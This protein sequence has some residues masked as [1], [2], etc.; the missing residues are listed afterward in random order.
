MAIGVSTA[1]ANARLDA[2]ESTIGVSPLLRLYSGTKPTDC[3]AALSGNT[4]LAEFNLPS[5]W[6]A[7]AVYGMKAGSGLNWWEVPVIATGTVS[8]FR[9][10]DTTGT[11]CHMQGTVSGIGG[12]GSLQMNNTTL[13][14]VDS[15]AITS[16]YLRASEAPVFSGALTSTLASLGWTATGTVA[17]ASWTSTRFNQTAYSNQ[18]V[19]RNATVPTG[20]GLLVSLWAKMPTPVTSHPTTL[21]NTEIL[22]VNFANWY[23]RCIG[24]NFNTTSGSTGDFNANSMFFLDGTAV[25][26]NP[27]SYVG[28]TT[29]LLDTG[30]PW[31]YE[32]GWVFFAF[33]F[34][35]DGSGNL[36]LNM[37]IRYAGQAVQGPYT[38]NYTLANIRAD[39]QTNSGWTLAHANAFT[40]SQTI[41]EIRINGD[42][43]SDAYLIHA[44]VEQATTTATNAHIL[45]ISNLTSAD[46][47]AWADWS[48]EW[49]GSL[50]LADRSGNSRDLSSMGGT[51]SAGGTFP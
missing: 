18:W 28:D 1:V 29:W 20:G 46:A 16:F 3:A 4:L 19:Y 44:R 22:R 30:I 21:G 26:E 34:V 33:Q 50:N 47:T 25:S 39:V 45:D 10:Y 42:D 27:D 12:G 37:W 38:T 36:T 24:F 11:T 13:T 40:P 7:S 51:M 6:M 35:C 41:S 14:S 5:D 17:T 49:G 48:L 43:G 32:N 15:V 23:M 9:I 2:I 8:F 31:T